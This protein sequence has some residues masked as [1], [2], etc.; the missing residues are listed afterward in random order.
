MRLSMS[1]Y[2]HIYA[3]MQIVEFKFTIFVKNYPPTGFDFKRQ[4]GLDINHLYQPMD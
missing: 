3:H 2:L 4:G 1:A